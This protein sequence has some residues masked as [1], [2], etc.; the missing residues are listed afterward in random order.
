LER[1]A[2]AAEAQGF[3]HGVSVTSSEGNVRLA[4]RLGRDPADA[5]SATRGQVE[6]AGFRLEPTPTRNDPDHHTLVLPQPVT[7]EVADT[8]NRVFGRARR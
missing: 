8:F 1:Q 5:A 6:D 7:R 2:Q 3:P 4:E